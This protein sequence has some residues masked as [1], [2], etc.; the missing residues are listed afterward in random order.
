MAIFST[1][2]NL[3]SMIECFICSYTTYLLHRC[4]LAHMNEY[5]IFIVRMNVWLL[6]SV[7]VTLWPIFVKMHEHVYS[8]WTVECHKHEILDETTVPIYIR[9][10]HVP[11]W[12]HCSSFHS[13]AL[14]MHFMRNETE[15]EAFLRKKASGISLTISMICTILRTRILACGTIES[16]ETRIGEMYQL[17]GTGNKKSLKEK[18]RGTD[19]AISCLR[20][21]SWLLWDPFSS[22]WCARTPHQPNYTLA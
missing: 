7:C 13:A 22:C 1:I 17:V 9:I 15:W 5:L 11:W 16:N 4:N 14:S 2:F 3:W 21:I 20:L 12:C 19:G 10:L 18:S 6:P 8:L